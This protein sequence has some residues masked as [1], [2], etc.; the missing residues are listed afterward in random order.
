M[1]KSKVRQI[2]EI[3]LSDIILYFVLP[4]I[5]IPSIWIIYSIYWDHVVIL[6]SII[7]I[8]YILVRRLALGIILMY[9]AFA[10]LRVREMCRFEPTCSTYAMIAIKKYGLIIGIIMGLN[11]ISRCHYPNGGKDYPKL[12]KKGEKEHG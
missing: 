10:P 6:I 3:K 7:I 8:T 5:L 9:K 4:I 12:F 1:S 2:R 11:R